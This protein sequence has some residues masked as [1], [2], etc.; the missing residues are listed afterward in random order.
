MPQSLSSREATAQHLM[1][2]SGYVQRLLRYEAKQLN[3]RWTA[4]MV[5]KDLQVLGPVSQR[6]L[7]E[8]EQVTAP[9]MTV[10]IQQMAER[11]W[12]RREGTEADARVSLISITAVGRQELKR[13]GGL[14][15][16][17]LEEELIGLSEGVLKKLQENLGLLSTTV[18]KKI[19]RVQPELE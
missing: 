7:A 10:L 17:R 6:T 9:T 12:V 13:A 16:A 18:M 5:L 11:K 3:I 14:L 1:F 8:I 19:H 4:L 15:R 2:I